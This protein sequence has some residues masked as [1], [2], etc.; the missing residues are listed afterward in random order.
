M[1]AAMIGD[2]RDERV[3]IEFLYTRPVAS[4]RRLDGRLHSDTLRCTVGFAYTRGLIIIIESPMLYASVYARDRTILGG[5]VMFV[6][7]LGRRSRG[8]TRHS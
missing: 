3:T 8:P 2:D 6:G 1:G 5:E 7:G 4:K